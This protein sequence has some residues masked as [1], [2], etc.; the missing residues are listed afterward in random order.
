MTQEQIQSVETLLVGYSTVEKDGEKAAELLVHLFSLLKN[1][2]FLTYFYLLL[3]VANYACSDSLVD[4]SVP[5]L[6]LQLLKTHLTSTVVQK[7]SARHFKCIFCC[8]GSGPS[9]YGFCWIPSTI[10]GDVSS[11]YNECAYC[12]ICWLS[13]YS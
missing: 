12:K 3:V 6:V 2:K 8:Y 5:K 13:L 4:K 7:V 9:T 10:V 1:C 11:H